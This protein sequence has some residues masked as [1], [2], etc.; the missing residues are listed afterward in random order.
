MAH[1]NRG[2]VWSRRASTTRPSP[3]STRRSDSLRR[4]PRRSTTG[5]PVWLDKGEYAQGHRRLQRDAPARSPVRPWVRGSR[6]D[7][8][9]VL[10]R[11]IP[12]RKARRRVGDACCEL[13]HWKKA[14]T[15]GI[16]AAACAEA[17]DYDAAVKWQEKALELTKDEIDQELGRD[18]LAL[19]QAKRPL[20]DEPA[21]PATDKVT[22]G[23]DV[24]AEQ[25]V[26]ELEGLRRS[27]R[28]SPRARSSSPARPP[29]LRGLLAPSPT[30][31][32]RSSRSTN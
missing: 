10:R 20:R 8:G 18:R 23:V 13:T 31:A 3:T 32:P 30:S 26:A 11:K 21:V 19:Y 17:G 27:T 16:L 7:L 6:L 2:A 9:H 4:T 28:R 29:R 5:P 22:T 1:S 15:L 14:N 12:R 25:A 24:P